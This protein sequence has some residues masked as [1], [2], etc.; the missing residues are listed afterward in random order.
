MFLGV[1][2]SGTEVKSITKDEYANLTAISAPL[3]YAVYRRFL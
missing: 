3:H 2:I 1:A